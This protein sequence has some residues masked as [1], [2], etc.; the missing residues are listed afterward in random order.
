MFQTR[1]SF[2]VKQDILTLPFADLATSCKGV[3]KLD[4]QNIVDEF[5]TK[6]GIKQKSWVYPQA[7]AR[8]AKWTLSRG[9][10]GKYASISMLEDNC[11]SSLFDLGLYHFL[12]VSDRYVQKQYS[13]GKDY[14]ALVPLI[15]AAHK[16][17]NNIQYS[18][19]DTNVS[20]LVD[21]RLY[22]AMVCK[23]TEYTVEEILEAR[24]LGL[25]VKSGKSANTV[26]SP[27]STYGLNGLP[28]I[29]LRGSVQIEGIGALPPLVRMMI[30]QTWCAHPSNR[31]KYMVLNPADW[32]SMP[33]PLISDSPFKA[34]PAAEEIVHEFP[35]M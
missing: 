15:L 34:E 25:T 30:C 6:F 20:A 16:K 7:L 5:A 3:K 11:K 8:V 18:E 35:W 1:S 19:W 28:S 23:H 31:T 22:A 21:E 27:I 13:D 17:Y 32:D 24:E 2:V 29:I 14:C 9:E 4:R 12:T 33:T 26:K 10:G